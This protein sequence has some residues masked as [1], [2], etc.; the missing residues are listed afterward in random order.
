MKNNGRT[1]VVFGG[2]VSVVLYYDGGDEMHEHTTINFAVA[3]FVQI[4]DESEQ[5]V[6]KRKICKIIIDNKLNVCVCVCLIN[7][8]MLI[9]CWKHSTPTFVRVWSFVAVAMCSEPKAIR[10]EYMRRFQSAIDFGI[11]TSP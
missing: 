5:L 11:W 6:N 7:T 1:V 9:W 4:A 8:C 2:R 3:K 10:I